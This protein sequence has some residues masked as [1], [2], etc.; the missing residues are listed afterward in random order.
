[1]HPSWRDLVVDALAANPAERQAFLRAA[2]LPGIELALSV[3][4]GASGERALPLLVADEDWDALGDAVHRLARE[5]SQSDAR[6]TLDALAI[7]LDAAAEDDR[8]HGEL[9]STTELALRTIRRRI[10]AWD[11]DLL[12]RWL[13][14]AEHL[15]QPPAPPDLVET[16]HARRPLTVD[17]D[18]PA[19]VAALDAWLAV[20]EA[21]AA[22]HPDGADI[23][24]YLADEHPLLRDVVRDLEARPR[25]LREPELA[26]LRRIWGLDGVLAERAMRLVQGRGHAEPAPGA[27]PL[28]VSLPGAA[29]AADG[30][31]VRRILLDL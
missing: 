2:E 7:A 9:V 19:S 18:D 23:T 28:P 31:R 21:L 24:P 11:A 22:W 4:G 1:V 25:P 13:T 6:R 12:E 8:A 30:R 3:G 5:A 29:A 17:V 20:V 27:E 10:R 26:A 14:L 16:W 15:P